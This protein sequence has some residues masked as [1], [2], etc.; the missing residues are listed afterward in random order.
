MV[1]IAK[2]NNPGNDSPSSS[3]SRPNGIGRSDRDSLHRLR[4]GEEA[5]HNKNDSDDA[6][7][8]LAKPLAVF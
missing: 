8:D 4:D 2:E 6:G 1:G 5:H 7:H 3:D